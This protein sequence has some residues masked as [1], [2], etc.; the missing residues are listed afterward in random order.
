MWVPGLV[1]LVMARYEGVPLHA[2]A[3]PNKA[4]FKAAVTAVAIAVVVF[5]ASVPFGNYVGL[6]K[7]RPG[8]PPSL[9]QLSGLGFSLTIGA[10]LTLAV[11]LAGLTVNMLAALGEELM[12]RGY[13]WQAWQHLG[14]IRASLLI[15]GA[16]GIW[17]APII[18]GFGHNYPDNPWLGAIAMLAFTTAA[19]PLMLAYRRQGESVLV[20]AVFHGTLNACGPLVLVI[21]DSPNMLIVGFTGIIGIAVLSTASA[22]AILRD[23]SIKSE[24]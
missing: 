23:T 5:A 8:L 17:H 13:L 9:N 3:K 7:L 20:P 4:Y 10:V 6:E 21:F 24:A 11:L 19:T 14:L 16:W 18:I 2:L 15:G 12:W 1:A 22:F